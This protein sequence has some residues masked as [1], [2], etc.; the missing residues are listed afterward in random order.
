MNISTQ[1]KK[2]CCGCTA[3]YSICPKK[4]IKMELDESGFYYPKIDNEKCINCE[5]CLKVC[6]FKIFKPTDNV[7]LA[8]AIKSKDD[9]EVC[10]S[11]S[12]AFFIGLADYILKRDGVVFGCEMTDKK[13]IIHKYALTKEEV[14][15]F[16]GSKYVQS[17]IRNCFEECSNFLLNGKYVLFSGTGCQIHG[18]IS[19]LK[20]KKINCE[21]LVTVDFVCHGVP[22]PQ[23]WSK[24]IDE[25]EKRYNIQIESINFRDKQING[26]REHKETYQTTNGSK[27]ISNK[28]ARMFYS[29]LLFRESCYNC[30]YTTTNRNSDFTMGDYWGIDKNVPE[31]D[32]NK[33]VSLVLAHNEKAYHIVKEMNGDF[34]VFATNL[35]NSIQPQLKKPINKNPK[36]ELFWKKF[37][38][39]NEKTISKYFFP[40]KF[41]LFIEEFKKKIKK[42]IK[43]LL[44]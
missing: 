41:V 23:V 8:F 2:D 20:L 12:G 16:K 39:N 6:D 24:F 5:L 22:S 14:K 30:K 29:H 21:K 10:T 28:W 13:T 7:P 11:R 43:K 26:W 34:Y 37:K 38:N 1:Q 44:K 17:S 31:I 3:C 42:L 19:Y 40:N 15:R 18:L 35:E 32:D 4:A 33:G 9:N 25:F 27:I 36:Y